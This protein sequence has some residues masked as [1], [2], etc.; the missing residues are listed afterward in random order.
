[1]KRFISLYYIVLSALLMLTACQNDETEEQGAGLQPDGKVRVHLRVGAAGS[2]ST[3]AWSDE[4]NAVT[5]E[6]MNVW[7]VVVVDNSNNKVVSIYACKP[8]GEPDQEIDDY[9]ELPGIGNYRFYSFANMS[10][11]VVMS[12]LGIGGEGNA[13]V[14]SARTRSASAGNQYDDTPPQGTGGN[15]NNATGDVTSYVNPTGDDDFFSNEN[16]YRHN[17]YYSIAFAE[18]ATVTAA[19]VEAKTINVAGNNFDIT[20]ANGYGA[21][22]IPMSN[23]QSITITEETTAINLIVI[24]LMAKFELQVYNNGSSD[25]AIKSITLMDVT[26]NADDNLKLLPNLSLEGQGSME[27][28]THGDIQPNL[29]T[30]ATTANLTLYPTAAQ[31]AVSATG[32]KTTDTS[33][34]PVKFTFYVNESAMPTNAS[35]LFYLTLG[36]KEGSEDVQYRHALI[37]NTAANEWSYIA[38]NDY[39]VIPIVLTDWQFRIE[40]IAF[41]PIAGYPATM[42][43]SDA[44]KATFSTGG[45]IALQPY[46]K[47]R[48]ES[49]WR[50]FSDP[51]VTFV[52]IHWKN[53]DG[54]DQAVYNSDGTEKDATATIVK[55]AFDYD[56]VTNYIIGELNNSFSSGSH[57][58]AITV[59]VKVGPAG[60]QYT[61]S[62][63]CDVVLQK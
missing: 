52:S 24:R 16:L 35:G 62:F 27:V 12:L 34:N 44:L 61:Y 14:K 21:I 7:T 51:E 58:T 30:A 9:V 15:E 22:G 38:R 48:T 32:H 56:D 54:E 13:T 37:S 57:K 18:N 4:A 41:A 47:K 36:I 60:S 20:T 46:V 1:M 45:I 33:P 59:T 8:S 55:T 29:G 39:R 19:S 26:R 25:V 49:T 5:A 3:R 42:L 11:K 53:S 17:I 6:M 10:P 50:D 28:T 31:G 23:V 63:T 43:S 2:Q 40:P